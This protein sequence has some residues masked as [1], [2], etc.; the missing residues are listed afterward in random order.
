[1][2]SKFLSLLVFGVLCLASPITVATNAP[3]NTPSDNP[4]PIPQLTSEQIKEATDFVKTKWM[5][6]SYADASSTETLDIYLPN[7]GDGPFPT[8]IY[9]HGGGF[10]FGD[11][12][13]VITMGL[14]G[15]TLEHGYALV[16]INY[17]LSGEATFPAAIED[18][19]AAIR[20]IRANAKE[21]QLNPDRIALW[22]S[23][24]GGS[25]EIGRASCRERVYG[26]V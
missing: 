25:L 2:F 7:E 15:P 1:M 17:R 9:V 6:I 24:A 11:A 21:Y 8:V 5:G 4:P 10:E 13:E 22:G 19:K 23:S 20:F 12:N 16:P 26:L 3:T 18:V 14:L